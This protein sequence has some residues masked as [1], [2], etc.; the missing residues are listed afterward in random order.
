MIISR[1]KGP[2]AFLSMARTTRPRSPLALVLLALVV[3]EPLHPYRM[4]QMIKYRGQDK[5]ANVAQPNSVYQTID[6][7]QRAGLIEVRETTRDEG[8]PERTVYEATEEG[9]RTLRRWLE[10]LLSTPQRDFPDFPAALALAAVLEPDDVRRHLEARADALRQRL[11]ESD[12][13]G[14]QIPRLFL[15]EEE[16]KRAMTAAELEW[17]QGVI[18]DLKSGALAWSREWLESHKDISAPRP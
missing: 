7:L 10:T 6:S 5:I 2:V 17:A 13:S 15:L 4:Q 12:T 8:R 1:V 3:E 18:R 11:A 9:R 14:Y 16:Y